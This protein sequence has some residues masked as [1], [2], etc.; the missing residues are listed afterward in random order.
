[1]N[2]KNRG[3]YFP[4]FIFALAVSS[5]SCAYNEKEGEYG[6]TFE[7]ILNTPEKFADKTIAFQSYV[8]FDG[9]NLELHHNLSAM[10]STEGNLPPLGVNH[11]EWK[12]LK[13]LNGCLVSMRA[14]LERH[15]NNRDFRITDIIDPSPNGLLYHIA[16]DQMAAKGIKG[17]PRC[18]G[19]AIMNLM[20]T[21]K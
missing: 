7:Q 9:H 14:K 13:P 4:F 3:L 19:Q 15:P 11:S 21:P 6:V 2:I 17:K 12:Q 16:A 5:A 1:M 18:L 10:N 20:A 8:L